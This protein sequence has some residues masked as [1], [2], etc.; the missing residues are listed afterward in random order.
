MHVFLIKKKIKSWISSW[1]KLRLSCWS[2]H[3]S[4]HFP[5]YQFWPVLTSSLICSQ[6]MFNFKSCSDFRFTSCV[7]EISLNGLFMSQLHVCSNCL[8][9]N[10]LHC[11]S[12]RVESTQFSLHHVGLRLLLLFFSLRI[13][14]AFSHIPFLHDET[15]RHKLFWG[16]ELVKHFV[17]A[18]RADLSCDHET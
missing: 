12:A 8:M 10:Q 17:V 9:S 13:V 18:E 6:S 16:F 3:V 15:L 14:S 5:V 11:S 1:L 2:F 4:T 7:V